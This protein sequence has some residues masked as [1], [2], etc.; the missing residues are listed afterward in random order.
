MLP[1]LAELD[2]EEMRYHLLRITFLYAVLLAAYH[3]IVAFAR[4]RVLNDR[5]IM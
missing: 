5:V 1:V 3:K 4:N 2:A